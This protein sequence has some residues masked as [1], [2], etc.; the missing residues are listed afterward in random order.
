[1]I[2]WL[3]NKFGLGLMGGELRKVGEGKYGPRPKAVYDFL[4]GKKTWTSVFLGLAAA[5]CLA[6]KQDDVARYIA[7][8]GAMLLP[9]GLLD[10]GWH[11]VP[12]SW[13]S[14]RW[15]T[16]LRDHAA[17][18]AAV[19][20]ALEVRFRAC[21]P[22]TSDLLGRVHLTCTGGLIALTVLTAVS[23]WMFSEGVVADP[24]R[25]L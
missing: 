7:A 5:V 3:L 13:T 23:V 11:A 21:A 12:E 18:I 9:L 17:D 6:L 15:Y 8:A 10:K 24:P 22:A 20:V 1:M 19:L 4:K 14:M 2:R 16:F 25:P